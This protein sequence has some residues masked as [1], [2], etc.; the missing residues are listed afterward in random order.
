MRKLVGLS[1]LV[2]LAVACRSGPDPFGTM[3]VDELASALSR[4]DVHVFDANPGEVF[5]KAHVKGAKHVEYNGVQASDLP[6]DKAATLVFYCK[7][8]H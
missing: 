4:P 2:L 7:N 8:W 3:T 5:N 1:S 6:E